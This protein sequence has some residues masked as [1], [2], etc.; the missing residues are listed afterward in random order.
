MTNFE[1]AILPFIPLYVFLKL[2]KTGLKLVS[3]TA[4]MGWVGGGYKGGK[5]GCRCK[6]NYFVF[7]TLI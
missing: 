3:R 5:F 2:N 6:V 1:V 4:Q 7:L